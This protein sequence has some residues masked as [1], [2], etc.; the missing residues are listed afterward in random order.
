LQL[1]AKGFS[2]AKTSEL[3]SISKNTTAFHI[4]SIYRKLKINS[5]AEA[6]IEAARLGIIGLGNP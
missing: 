6:T 2:V 1:I 4:K 5:R 3:L